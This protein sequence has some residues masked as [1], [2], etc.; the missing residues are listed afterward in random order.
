M[1]LRTAMTVGATPALLSFG[2]GCCALLAGYKIVRPMVVRDGTHLP[3]AFVLM[4]CL[5][6][7]QVL[8]PVS[9]VIGPV[10]LSVT[11]ETHLRSDA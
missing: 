8:G 1:A 10:A 6:G 2:L 9:L 7:F 11:R 5:G 4:G 3:F